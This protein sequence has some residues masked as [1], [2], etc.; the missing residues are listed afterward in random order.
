MPD[1]ISTVGNG[2]SSPDYATLALYNAGDG[3][4]DPGV[5]F[6]SIA[7]CS[8]YLGATA[9]ING[10]FIRGAT[11][12]GDIVFDGTNDSSLANT[13]RLTI[14]SGSG[15]NV[16]DLRIFT[17]NQFVSALN[18][19]ADFIL[20]D[21]VVFDNETAGVNAIDING[22]FTNGHIRN[23][24]ARG[25]ADAVMAGFNQGT[26][27]TN[28]LV[29]GAVDKGVEGSSSAP[30]VLT[31]IFAFN[32]GGQDIDSAG[33][34]TLVACATEDSTGTYTGYTS[35]E[36]VDVASGDLRTKSTSDFATLGNPFIGAFLESGGSTGIELTPF[37]VESISESIA[38]PLN[39]TSEVQ[40]NPNL[41]KAEAIS[42]NPNITLAVPINISAISS[43]ANSEAVVSDLILNYQVDL[44][45]DST[46]SNSVGVGSILDLTATVEV[47]PNTIG[48]FSEAVT[49]ELNL[50]SN[51]ELKPVLTQALSTTLNPNISLGATLSLTPSTTSSISATDNSSVDLNSL[52]ELITSSTSSNS[53]TDNP[54]LTLSTPLVLQPLVSTSESTSSTPTIVTLD[55]V[56]MEPVTSSATS[57][58]IN[59]EVVNTSHIGLNPLVSQSVSSG[60][61]PNI[62]LATTLNINPNTTT[63]SSTTL[64]PN[65]DLSVELLISVQPSK[66]NAT[67]GNPTILVGQKLVI[68][69]FT[70]K[71]NNPEITAVFADGQ[72][73][74]SYGE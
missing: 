54:S 33:G 42:L 27:L 39:L 68:E 46:A 49:P 30:M 50:T 55:I 28:G 72:I 41:T 65:I 14:S 26:N 53:I 18:Y 36:L 45:P 74:I 17:N 70:I 16:E 7:E 40:L 48:V 29:Y 15:I 52:V 56:T 71:Y 57:T 62:L 73:N 60:D 38:V 20:M 44:T 37:T 5:G 12:R 32:N 64:L 35:A 3:G 31:N 19:N 10:T 2:H 11:I 4:L 23:F 25:G 59:P 66:S 9:N 47:K 67:S 61:N 13:D 6:T 43:S 69:S 24:V 34:F 51:V 21:R 63:S 58:A 8:G 1:I 22:A